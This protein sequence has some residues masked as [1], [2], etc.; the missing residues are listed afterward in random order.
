MNDRILGI[1][2]GPTEC[3]WAVITPAPGARAVY[4]RGGVTETSSIVHFLCAMTCSSAAPD[5]VC[6]ER[7][8]YRPIGGRDR[9]QQSIA[10]AA[11]LVDTAWIAGMIAGV[12]DGRA[13]VETPT[14]G[15]VRRALL[16]RP[17]AADSEVKWALGHYIDLPR[18]NAH[19]RD[20][21]AVALVGARIAQVREVVS[22]PEMA[23]GGK[24]ALAAI[25]AATAKAE[26]K[27]A[28]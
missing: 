25:A 2:P 6:I 15:E 26:Q 22:V 7:P 20:A 3:A 11:T 17:S 13:R 28:A 9:V 23:A 10:M 12:L 8:R 4:E 24:A 14:C 5:L 27:G 19:V 18:C 21:V 1:D 16:G